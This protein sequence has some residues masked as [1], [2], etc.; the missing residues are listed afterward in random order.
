MAKES[1][2]GQT[3]GAGSINDAPVQYRMAKWE[4]VGVLES[5]FV[6]DSK[7]NKLQAP[8]WPADKHI[9]RNEAIHFAACIERIGK[10]ATS[11]RRK[12]AQHASSIS[13]GGSHYCE[14]EGIE[15]AA[16]LSREEPSFD[17]LE[18]ELT[19][20]ELGANIIKLWNT[21]SRCDGMTGMPLGAAVKG[22][23]DC[24]LA[25]LF[26]MVTFGCQ[27]VA[28]RA[29]KRTKEQR[30]SLSSRNSSKILVAEEDF[31]IVL[32]RNAADVGGELKV[33]Q[34]AL[35]EVI[36]TLKD[37]VED[38]AGIQGVQTEVYYCIKMLDY[39]MARMRAQSTVSSALNASHFRDTFDGFTT[40]LFINL[41]C[42]HNNQYSDEERQHL[43]SLLS[44]AC[45]SEYSI[46]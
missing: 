44:N 10:V 19:C 18:E 3:K 22:G 32:D 45:E 41:S 27:R 43:F 23:Y 46:A 16:L 26:G 36:H 11:L 30:P 34:L 5:S 14:E 21:L 15:I 1:G 31:N 25:W 20:N 37:M 29:E 28:L 9:N 35:P 40:G 12:K 6:H 13:P 7:I 33:V 24:V 39:T 8:I 38:I 4:D 2:R 17:N 42:G